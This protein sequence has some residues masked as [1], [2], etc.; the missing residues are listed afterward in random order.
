MAKKQV[1]FLGVFWVLLLLIVIVC[2]VKVK[3]ATSI[4][5]SD[6]PAFPENGQRYWVIFTEGYRNSRVEL[7]T[8]DISKN[9][10]KAWIKWNRNLTL[11]GADC[12]GKYNQY[13]LND[14]GEWEQ[15]GTYNRFTDYATSVIVSNLDVKD[16]YGKVAVAKSQ[17]EGYPGIANTQYRITYNANGGSN[18]PSPQKF[19]S[20]SKV[21]ISSQVPV[22]SSY[23]FEGWGK[24]SKSTVVSYYS[25]KS[26]IFNKNMKLYA[27]WKKVPSCVDNKN[28]SILD[29]KIKKSAVLFADKFAKKAKSSD[30]I[31]GPSAIQQLKNLGNQV[32]ITGYDGT[33]SDEVLEAFA[34]AV[35]NTMNDA[36]IDEYE[37]NTNK[38]T[39]QIY[40]QIKDGV[41]II[42]QKI[43]IGNTTYTVDCTIL[44]QSY[45]SVGAQASWANVT[46]KDKKNKPYSVYIVTNSTDESM[47]KALASYCTVLAQLN[48]G[49]W[50][51]FLTKYVTG[52]WKLAGLNNVKKL[53]DK[54]VSKFFDH[55]ENLILV[56]CGDKKAKEF[57]VNDA[58]GI[59]KEQ[60]SKMTKTQFRKFIKK[61][62]A[63]G[64]KIVKA[65]DQYKK[66][67]D[68]Y[69]DYKKYL[70]KW[71]KSGNN[72]DLTKYKKA[73]DE[74]LKMIDSL[75][76]IFGQY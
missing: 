38:L 75:D 41:K 64:D 48:K 52:G 6:L 66:V 11:Q 21:K 27:V 70:R 25:G 18:A 57:F 17:Y 67:S 34:K 46:W 56:I 37:T 28:V 12:V 20:G 29:K 69:N 19:S 40:N 60:L 62:V 14:Y 49:M 5:L 33:V 9:A 59:L 42:S 54:T 43:T 65:A 35:L 23:T 53:D 30:E 3:A 16:I 4:S 55:S 26:Y 36:K 22:R 76:S 24:S 32:T 72:S 8:C 13:Y 15:I 39:L 74:C 31:T 73:Y 63:S 71:K 44:A 10:E 2:S 45:G 58:S 68:K 47:K 51:D 1:K 7:T 50:K 61:N